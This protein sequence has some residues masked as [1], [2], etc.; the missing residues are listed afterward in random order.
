MKNYYETLGVNKNASPQEIKKAYIKLSLEWHPDKNK[1]QCATEKFQEISAAYQVL[2]DSS[3]RE[4]Y[5]SGRLDQQNDINHESFDQSYQIFTLLLFLELKESLKNLNK[6]IHEINEVQLN[7]FFFKKNAF[8]DALKKFQDTMRK[9][10]SQPDNSFWALA[11]IK[12]CLSVSEKAISM[13]DHIQNDP[14]NS[15]QIAIVQ[16]RQSI[17]EQKGVIYEL[18]LEPIIADI[19]THGVDLKLNELD[20]YQQSPLYELDKEID[21]LYNLPIENEKKNQHDEFINSLKYLREKVRE[22]IARQQS[23]NVIYSFDTDSKKQ[24]DKEILASSTIT[25]IKHT[26]DMLKNLKYDSLN[27]DHNQAEILKYKK[28]CKR[29]L[30]TPYVTN[31]FKAVGAIIFTGFM[32]IST[33]GVM[34]C[35]LGPKDTIETA[36]I[37]FNI[38][39]KHALADYLSFKPYSLPSA[40]NKLANKA[41]QFT[42][43]SSSNAS[44]F[45]NR[46]SKP[47]NKRE[48]KRTDQRSRNLES[49]TNKDEHTPLL[50]V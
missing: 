24:T 5:D 45:F 7:G 25:L 18:Q 16:F 34:C 33:C 8:I 37:V 20:L 15:Y 32:F 42:K 10:A 6:K 47:E 38:P 22:D 35:V 1:N 9:Y 3:K 46:R 30:K 44:G 27:E 17:V 4:L 48:I 39:S 50:R 14:I 21:R 19:L 41:E 40:A 28:N 13:L 49:N 2:S 12:Q 29:D 31:F 11:R 23:K 26:V 36:K 43:S